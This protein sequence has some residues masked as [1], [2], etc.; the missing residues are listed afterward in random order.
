MEC[1]HSHQKTQACWGPRILPRNSPVSILG[2]GLG[3]RPVPPRASG[4]T[5]QGR[6]ELAFYLRLGI[7][8]QH[9]HLSV[10]R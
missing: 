7:W 10:Y 4:P 8:P 2:R 5:G 6:M 1:M 3:S 9:T